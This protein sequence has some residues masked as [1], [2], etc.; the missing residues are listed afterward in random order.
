MSQAPNCTRIAPRVSTAVVTVLV[1]TGCGTGSDGRPAT[2]VLRV[3]SSISDG[4]TL[5]QAVEWTAVPAGVDTGDPVTRVEFLIDGRRRWVDRHRPYFFNADHNALHPWI[6]A[7][8]AHR[9]AVRLR[10]RH[11]DQA[12]TVAV[13]TVAGRPAVPAAIAGVWTRRR[14]HSHREQGRPA[15]GRWRARFARDGVVVLQGPGRARTREAFS[16]TA[17][18]T[19][20][21]SGPVNWLDRGRDHTALCD[22]PRP[23]S[24][25]WHAHGSEL[26]LSTRHDSPCRDRAAVLAGTWTHR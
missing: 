1:A 10:T 2:R 22:H 4:A 5:T 8:G 15:A 12:S 20:I 6:L 7:R 3:I 21:L 13:V 19:L 17:G 11:G 23:A 18:G 16:A 9:L 25:R 14:G 26:V 24:Y